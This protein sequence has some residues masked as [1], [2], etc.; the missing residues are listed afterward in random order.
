MRVSVI[1]V[2]YF[3]EQFIEKC[4]NSIFQSTYKDIEVI[5]VDNDSKDE[6]KEV[7]QKYSESVRAFFLEKNIGFSAAN[8]YGARQA[9]G[10]LL[11]FLNHD[12]FVWRD[13]IGVLVEEYK[14]MGENSIIVAPRLLNMDG[15]VQH[16][17]YSFPNVWSVVSE[18]LF[19]N[20]FFKKKKVQEESAKYKK[21]EAVSGAAMMM[22]KKRFEEIGGW[23]ESLFW[24]DDVDFCYRNFLSGGRIF[25]V[26]RAK[27]YHLIGGSA[28]KFPEKVIP[29]QLMSRLKFFK[30]HGHF[31]EIICAFIF[32]Y[33]Q[34]ISR[35]LIFSLLSPFNY[36]CRKKCVGYL[37]CVILLPK[38]LINDEQIV[39]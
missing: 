27:S 34:A 8:N 12:A 30:K 20:Y 28:K 21:C 23:D 13:C 15:S 2:S 1:I 24:M 37:R 3:S 10:E 18:S 29:N 11:F 9:S 19:L 5:L 32:L 39:A 16:S 14:L 35:G 36:L 22:S 25:Q 38:T 33:F 26:L 7:V 6:T 4:L 31:F 17:D